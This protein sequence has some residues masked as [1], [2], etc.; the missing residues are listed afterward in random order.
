MKDQTVFRRITF[1]CLIVMVVMFIV[2][3]QILVTFNRQETNVHGND[4][5]S[6]AYMEID[7]RS[8][9]TSSWLKRDFALSA[10]QT[11]DLTGQTVD[12]TLY[13]NSGDTIRDWGLRINIAGDCFINQ[14]WTGEVEIHQFVESGAEAVQRLNLQDYRLEDVTLAYRYD[15]DLLIPLQKGDYLL[16]Y[17]N[18]HYTEMPVRSGDKVTIGMIFYYL[19]DLDLSDYDLTVHFHRGFAQGW[20]FIAFVVAAALFVLS[21]VVY[22]TGLFTYRNAQKQLELRRS[23]LSYMSELYEAIYII[24]LPTGEITPVSPGEYVEDLR[25]KYS[26]AKELL[27]AAVRGD[28]EE[29]YLDAALAFVDPDTLPDRLKDQ[30]SLVC[31]FVSRK[32]SWCRFRFFAMERAEGKPLENVIFAVQDINDERNEAKNLTERLARAESAVAAGNAFLDTASRDLQAPVREV[33]SLNEQ[34]LQTSDPGKVRES[35]ENIRCTADRMLTLV[36]ALADR[37][38]AL[39]GKGK[40]AADPYSLRQLTAAALETVRPMA[41]KKQIRLETEIPET[42]PD[43]LLGDEAKLREVTVSLLAYAMNHSLDGS[44]RLSVFGKVQGEN[45][46][47]L[48][49]VRTLPEAADSSAGPEARKKARA[50]P[51]LDLEVA[52]SLLTA[53]DSSLK[54]VCSA[55]A[56]K[57]IYFEID[58]QVASSPAAEGTER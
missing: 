47:L 35:A 13:N 22:V 15:G 24:N 55:D 42:L 27:C 36:S 32:H 43:A 34:I 3:V 17:P 7:P 46:H 57:D 51:D 54:S 5:T 37:A 6:R 44:V 23:G 20:S 10:D 49:S 52:G 28:V 41:E 38:A 25:K 40:T 53:L 45:V 33:L 18:E 26:N 2:H 30:D 21:S 31:E 14:A 50:V 1:I 29:V 58:Q 11:A 8:N 48:F 9:S 19:N 56:W 4:S 16:Y 39:A 12:Q